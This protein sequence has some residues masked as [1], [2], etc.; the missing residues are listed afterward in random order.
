MLVTVAAGKSIVE[1]VYAAP[2]ILRGITVTPGQYHHAGRRDGMRIVDGQ[3]VNVLVGRALKRLARI[4]TVITIGIIPD[5]VQVAVPAQ[6][7][8]RF[9]RHYHWLEVVSILGIAIIKTNI[10]RVVTSVNRHRYRGCGLSI[11]FVPGEPAISVVNS[12]GALIVKIIRVPAF[13]PAHCAVAVRSDQIIIGLRKRPHIAIARLK[14]H[15]GRIALAM[16]PPVR[17]RVKSRSVNLEPM[18]YMPCTGRGFF[19]PREDNF[20]IATHIPE[21]SKL[22]PSCRAVSV[23]PGESGRIPGDNV[24]V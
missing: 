13:F 19:I 15:T 18:Q 22:I 21:L 20:T 6:F 2:E 11:G 23:Y 10:H 3:S 7:T 14:R 1:R 17:N 8:G 5:G 12:L 9:K 4:D 16:I 24:V